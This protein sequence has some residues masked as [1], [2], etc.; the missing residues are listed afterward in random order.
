MFSKVQD[1]AVTS[2]GY[3][4]TQ[5]GLP[6][7]YPYLDKRKIVDVTRDEFG[8][9]LSAEES[10]QNENFSQETQTKLAEL[11]SGCCVIQYR[12]KVIN[13]KGEEEEMLLPVSAWK[14]K[15]STRPYICKTERLHF[16]TLCKFDTSEYGE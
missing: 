8:Q 16:L 15:A 14:G 9:I 3:R 13:N 11:G 10:A 7:L 6:I 2:C 4:I 1:K 5:E 12:E